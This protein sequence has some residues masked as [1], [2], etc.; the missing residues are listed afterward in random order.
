MPKKCMNVTMWE[1][2]TLDRFLDVAKFTTLTPLSLL[3]PCKLSLAIVGFKT[4]SLP[5]SAWKSNKYPD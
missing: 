3:I 2:Y 4:S 5:T 1:L